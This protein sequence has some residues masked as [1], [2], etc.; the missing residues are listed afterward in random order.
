LGRRSAASSEWKST[1]AAVANDVMAQE[2]EL[3]ESED[4][5][6]VVES[7]VDSFK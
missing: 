5:D 2:D 3:Q 7:I 4:E 6:P 1:V